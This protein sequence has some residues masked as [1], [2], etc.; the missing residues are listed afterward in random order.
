MNR[1]QGVVLLVGSV[2]LAVVV[3]FPPWVW[4]TSDLETTRTS[5]KGYHL[6]TKP[7]I[8]LRLNMSYILL[9]P[10]R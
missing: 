1:G 8:E 6:I 9:K 4:V 7:C 5:S 10:G 2:V 3:L